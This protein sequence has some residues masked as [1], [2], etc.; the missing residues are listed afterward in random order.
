MA[1]HPN[2][3][4]PKKREVNGWIQRCIGSP[5]LSFGEHHLPLFICALLVPEYV[6]ALVIRQFLRAREIVRENKGK[7][8][9]KLNF[10]NDNHS[11]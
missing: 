10:I 2:V 7:F 1:V 5:L 6:L 8:K 9:Y 11:K 3:P 4:C